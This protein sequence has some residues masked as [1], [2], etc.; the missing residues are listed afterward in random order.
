M[1]NLKARLATQAIIV[2]GLLGVS[3]NAAAQNWVKQAPMKVARV[4]ATTAP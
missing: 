3:A 1:L 2:L 4:E